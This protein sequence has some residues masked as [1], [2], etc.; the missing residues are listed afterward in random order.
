VDN[1][2]TVVS[3]YNSVKFLENNFIFINFLYYILFIA[4]MYSETASPIPILGFESVLLCILFF[5]Y[6][7]TYYE[8]QIFTYD[9]F[10]TIAI[11]YTFPFIALQIATNINNLTLM[12]IILTAISFHVT[13]N[14]ILYIY[15][16][17]NKFI[18]FQGFYV[19]AGLLLVDYLYY[20]VTTIPLLISNDTYAFTVLFNKQL[21]LIMFLTIVRLTILIPI[22]FN[23]NIFKISY[24]SSLLAYLPVM[25]I[26]YFSYYFDL[27][28]TF[29]EIV[30]SITTDLINCTINLLLVVLV[31]ENYIF[32]NR[33]VFELILKE[34]YR[35]VHTH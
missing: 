33:H 22:K 21:D 3:K 10:K 18:F 28:V 29:N 2:R 9:I 11:T 27:D 13:F 17:W 6:K 23:L 12:L 20:M 26:F 15:K 4:F 5:Q 8:R 35:Y 31:I 25:I 24:L 19:L 14:F 16:M 1:L 34:R 32:K 7:N 30:I